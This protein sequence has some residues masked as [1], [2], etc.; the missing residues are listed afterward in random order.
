MKKAYCV[1]VHMLHGYDT[2]VYGG[3]FYALG[4]NSVKLITQNFDS[5]KDK[6]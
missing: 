2:I 3:G 1:T 4:I 5:L 6:I